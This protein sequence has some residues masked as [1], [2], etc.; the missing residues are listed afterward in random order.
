VRHAFTLED[1]YR[2]GD[3]FH[4]GHSLLLDRSHCAGGWV[5]PGGQAAGESLNEPEGGVADMPSPVRLR[6]ESDPLHVHVLLAGDHIFRIAVMRFHLPW[7]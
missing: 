6:D 1:L 5:L 7:R 4:A 2:G 3:S